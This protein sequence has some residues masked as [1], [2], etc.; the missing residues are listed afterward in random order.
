MPINTHT[1]CTH[2]A[3]GTPT[4]LYTETLYQMHRPDP[5]PEMA[6]VPGLLQCSCAP[7]CVLLLVCRDISLLELVADVT[8]E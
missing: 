5:Q 4:G 7:V 8:C 1:Y 2:V 6:T 3:C